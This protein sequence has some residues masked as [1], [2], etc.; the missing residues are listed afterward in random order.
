M[1][2]IGA[3]ELVRFGWYFLISK[4]DPAGFREWLRLV[5]LGRHERFHR[6]P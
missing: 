1:R 4:R 3:L 5:R 2:L 6:A